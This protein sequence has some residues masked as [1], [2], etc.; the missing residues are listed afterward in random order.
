MVILFIMLCKRIYEYLYMNKKHKCD[1][2]SNLIPNKTNKNIL[3]I[4]NQCII[5]HL[6]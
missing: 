4:I 5:M 2:L 1:K 3:F 6:L